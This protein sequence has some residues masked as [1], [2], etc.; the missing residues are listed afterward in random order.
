MLLG[1]PF[2]MLTDGHTQDYSDG[3]QDLILRDPNTDRQ[4]TIATHE[5]TRKE[6][7]KTGF[8]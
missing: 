5:R 1:R 7:P 2:F 3:N 6:D 8:Q 4:L